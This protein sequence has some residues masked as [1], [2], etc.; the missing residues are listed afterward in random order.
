MIYQG[1]TIFFFYF[2]VF[3]AS[4]QYSPNILFGNEY[5][6]GSQNAC[7]D[8]QLRQYYKQTPPFK[9][10]FFVAKINLTVDADHMPQVRHCLFVYNISAEIDY[11][12]SPCTDT[13]HSPHRYQ[14]YRTAFYTC[15]H[16]IKSFCYDVKY[17]DIGRLEQ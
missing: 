12:D 14:L 11:I 3:D 9:T 13:L 2:T 8:L 17:S 1:I 4:G 10:T 16:S 7:A 15:K 6:L 5:W